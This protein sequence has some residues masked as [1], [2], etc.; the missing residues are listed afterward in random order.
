MGLTRVSHGPLFVT[1]DDK[2]QWAWIEDKDGTLL[3]EVGCSLDLSD[4][5]SHLR[6]PLVAAYKWAQAENAKTPPEDT[7]SREEELN[8]WRWWYDQTRGNFS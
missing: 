6:G 8:E 3:C 2:G 1:A 7:Y 5:P 4:V